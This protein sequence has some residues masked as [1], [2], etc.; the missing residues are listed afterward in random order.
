MHLE[1]SCNFLTRYFE[2]WARDRSLP[3]LTSLLHVRLAARLQNPP[4]NMAQ[5]LFALYTY[6]WPA[7]KIR[8]LAKHSASVG[9]T[10]RG[11]LHN[12]CWTISRRTLS[13]IVAYD[14]RNLE[15]LGTRN[16]VKRGRWLHHGAIKGDAHWEDTL[17][18]LCSGNNI[19]KLRTT[20][21]TIKFVLFPSIFKALERYTQLHRL[22]ES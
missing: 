19:G 16:R 12:L 18:A 5:F 2:Q 4:S 6:D 21:T 13:S 7:D 22:K 9:T 10:S 20:A 8:S 17:Q 1:P 11:N 14:G 3:I 15:S